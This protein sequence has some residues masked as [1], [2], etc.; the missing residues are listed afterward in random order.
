MQSSQGKAAVLSKPHLYRFSL[1][2][3]FAKGFCPNGENC[4][5]AHAETELQTAHLGGKSRPCVHSKKSAGGLNPV[6]SGREDLKLTHAHTVEKV[7]LCRQWVMEGS[8]PRGHKCVHAHGAEE[9]R[10]RKYRFREIERFARREGVDLEEAIEERLSRLAAGLPPDNIRLAPLVFDALA[11]QL[12]RYPKSFVGSSVPPEGVGGAFGGEGREQGDPPDPPPTK[13]GNAAARAEEREGEGV[14]VK[15]E[16]PRGGKGKKSKHAVADPDAFQVWLLHHDCLLSYLS[17]LDREFLL[18]I[19]GEHEGRQHTLAK[20]QEERAR[21]LEEED[22]FVAQNARTSKPHSL[23]ESVDGKSSEGGNGKGNKS[24]SSSSHSGNQH[25]SKASTTPA[26]TPTPPSDRVPPLDQEFN[27]HL[28]NDER[29]GTQVPL[30]LS[31]SSLSVGL[32]ASSTNLSQTAPAS[33]H[34]GHP[35]P[36]HHHSRKEDFGLLPLPT[37]ATGPQT[38]TRGGRFHPQA[39]HPSRPVPLP[40]AGTRPSP[41]ADN[42]DSERPPIDEA[43]VN[44]EV[45]VGI[46]QH[47][48][49]LGPRP[50]PPPGFERLSSSSKRNSHIRPADEL[51]VSV[52]IL[53]VVPDPSFR[54]EGVG[55]DRRRV[56]RGRLHLKSGELNGSRVCPL[57]QNRSPT[58][59]SGSSGQGSLIES[60]PL[61][62]ATPVLRKKTRGEGADG[63]SGGSSRTARFGLSSEQGSASASNPSRGAERS[64]VGS[65]GES[66]RD[67]EFAVSSGGS[68]SSSRDSGEDEEEGTRSSSSSFSGPSGTER[69]TVQRVEPK[70]KEERIKAPPYDENE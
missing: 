13:G 64:S 39:P 60:L 31:A 34:Q 43:G 17:S 23:S 46:Q 53:P 48:P 6:T 68:A 38:K 57:T 3:L 22:M 45:A 55:A 50:P 7:A 30:P 69:G 9:L 33:H 15:K 44:T 37:A 56:S 35:P 63:W 19:K 18:L 8:C 52:D 51:D 5:F 61:T 21:E 24:T 66:A 28:L 65:G 70:V 27:N 29:G 54:P 49:P 47:R 26:P 4:S 25:F 41:P 67:G 12:R 42:F 1:C 20:E 40:P 11:S 2:R 59:S 14:E 32:S 36:M 16:P 62:D 10:P 58:P